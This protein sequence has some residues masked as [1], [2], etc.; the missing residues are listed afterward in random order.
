MAPRHSD[1][2]RNAEGESAVG[3]DSEQRRI[4]EAASRVEE[5]R[6]EIKNRKQELKDCCRKGEDLVWAQFAK[7]K[8]SSDVQEKVG[9][10]SKSKRKRAKSAA[11]Q[12]SSTTQPCHDDPIFTPPSVPRRTRISDDILG[13]AADL[14]ERE[15]T[16]VGNCSFCGVAAGEKNPLVPYWMAR[17]GGDPVLIMAEL[18]RKCDDLRLQHGERGQVAEQMWKKWRNN[19]DSVQRRLRAR[20]TVRIA[21]TSTSKLSHLAGTLYRVVLV[22]PDGRVWLQIHEINTRLR[23]LT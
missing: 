3:S 19:H 8:H 12:S 21:G 20:M 1:D 9:K 22:H 23:L 15:E 7:S 4:D 14:L 16:F 5:L 17:S 10:F 11:Q 6:K 18:C 2:E 13:F